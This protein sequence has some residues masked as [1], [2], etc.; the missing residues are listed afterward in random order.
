MHL[1]YESSPEVVICPFLVSFISRNEED[2]VISHRDQ[3][4]HLFFGN[5]SLVMVLPRAVGAHK[6]ISSSAWG[7]SNQYLEI[8]LHCWCMRRHEV[9]I[10]Y[11]WYK[12]WASKLED[13]GWVVFFLTSSCILV[14]FRCIRCSQRCLF[15]YQMRSVEELLKLWM[16]L[17]LKH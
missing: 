6:S 4:V 1:L 2:S 14:I 8:R 10:L 17:E 12:L 7:D 13:R 16:S 9:Y 3:W 11:K 15:I 5:H